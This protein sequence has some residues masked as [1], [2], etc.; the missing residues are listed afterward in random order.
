MNKKSQKN[1]GSSFRIVIIF[2]LI[3]VGASALL[4]GGILPKITKSVPPNQGQEYIPITPAP[5]ENSQGSS[6]L[7]IKTFGFKSPSPIPQNCAE[8]ITVDFL[9]DR[10]GS[11]TSLTPTGKRKIERLKEAVLELTGKLDDA[12]VVGIQSF[13]TGNITNDVPISYYKDVKTLIPTKV[14]ALNAG[15]TTPTHDALAYSYGVLQEALPRFKD[16]KFNFILISDGQP[17]PDSQ[18]P[19]L[20]NPNPADQIKALGVNVFTLAVYDSSQANDPKLRDLLK[21]IASKP[22]NYYEAQN[23][24]DIARLLTQISTKLCQ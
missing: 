17:V 23:A 15:G 24:D 13:S 22:E 5:G 18:D 6:N 11:M 10:T 8:T 14:N 7:Q 20:F 16:R 19:R 2:L 3:I 4:T 9:L 1:G 21:S 12:S